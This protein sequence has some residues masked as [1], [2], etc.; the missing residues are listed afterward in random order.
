MAEADL[1][2]VI[3]QTARAQTK[4]VM[5]AAR[6]RQA[7]W[8]ARAGK[9][10]DKSE[11]SDAKPADKSDQTKADK[12]DTTDGLAAAVDATATA[13]TGATNLSRFLCLEK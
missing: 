2:A 12:N 9:A 1:D 8:V 13:Q 4:A 6:K 3:R 11:T 10:K 5:A 7:V